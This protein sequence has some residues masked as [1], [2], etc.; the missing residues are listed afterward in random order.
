MATNIN[1]RK[2][3]FTVSDGYFYTFD[4][5]QDALLQKTDDGNT[6][7]SYPCD[8]LLDNTIKSLEYDGVNF[9]SLEAATTTLYIKR[10][11]IHNYLAKL[12]QTITLN[13]SGSMTYSAD[14]FTI[15]HYHTH[16]TDIT[17][18]GDT[19][20]YID[21]YSNNPEVITNATLHIGPNTN[22]EEEDIAVVG[23]VF[24]GVV[25]A[26]PLSYGYAVGNEINFHKNIWLFNNNDGI[27]TTTG[28]LYKFDSTTGALITKFVGGAYKAIT[29][30]TFY[31][32]SSFQNLGSKDMLLYAKGTNTLFVNTSA[33][34]RNI[35]D[36]DI[37]D[38]TF[39]TLDAAKWT[40]VSGTPTIQSGELYLNPAPSPSEET[41]QTKYYLPED[42]DVTI[43]GQLVA[44]NTSY[45]GTGYMENSFKLI[46]PNEQDRFCKVSRGYSTEFGTALHQNFSVTYRKATDGVVTTVSGIEDDPLTDIDTYG[47]R[48]KRVASDV[49][50]YYRTTTAA[51]FTPWRY[52]GVIEMFDTDAQLVLSSFNATDV[53]VINTFDNLTFIE[54][55]VMNLTNAISLPYYGSMVMDNITSNVAVVLQDMSVDRNNLYRLQGSSSFDYFLSPLE[56]FV[57]SISL[58]AS[59]AIIAA[60]GLST[61]NI[62]AWV[63]DQFLQPIQNRRVTFSEGGDGMITGGTELNTD[64]DGFVQTIYKAGTLAQDVLVTATVQQTN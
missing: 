33:Y 10:W 39:D 29:A 63:K 51:V 9:W 37:M 52:L 17:S 56:S 55:T 12:Q 31:K 16:L 18:P 59:P 20:I 57:T 4:E 22:G 24:G 50:F 36:A 44:Y 7:F 3:N 61:T 14:A 54:G 1:I 5:D 30:C 27:I 2:S 49:H 47:L 62:N 6:A 28:A 64:A 26:T 46:F 15:E 43:D 60:N 32:I 13:S 40:T 53:T 35:Y 34:K 38:D 8:I 42:F 58:S 11:R 45:S 41:I 19:I 23:T 21:E 48:I 25:L